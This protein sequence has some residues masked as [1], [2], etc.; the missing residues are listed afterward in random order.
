MGR[1]LE[2]NRSLGFFGGGGGG[3]GVYKLYYGQ[4]ENGKLE[5]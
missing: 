2:R 3:G 4:C 1:H 5:N